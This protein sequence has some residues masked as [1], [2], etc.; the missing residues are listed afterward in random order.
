VDLIISYRPF[1]ALM[2]K[3]TIFVNSVKNKLSKNMR[4]I[5]FKDAKRNQ[6][7]G[8]KMVSYLTNFSL[9]TSMLYL[10][11][12]LLNL[13]FIFYFRV[14]RG[15][16]AETKDNKEKNKLKIEKLVTD[17]VAT[18]APVTLGRI[19]KIFRLK[20]SRLIYSYNFLEEVSGSL[21]SSESVWYQNNLDNN[22]N[23]TLE[24][25]F[26]THGACKNECHGNFY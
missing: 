16:K 19:P 4:L 18:S 23:T 26:E 5:L 15:C 8:S 24:V 21:C 12:Y 14:I 6:I 9:S 10:I 11:F 22:P 2:Q 13:L 20:R 1:H 25:M 17:N 3:T 7:V